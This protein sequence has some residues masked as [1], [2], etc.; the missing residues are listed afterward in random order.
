MISLI[1]Q[2]F[3]EAPSQML[4]N[5]CWKKNVLDFVSRHY[6]TGEPL[7]ADLI[8][9]MQKAKDV[10]QGLFN[11]RQL[12]FGLFDMKL[13]TDY[14]STTESD[15]TQLW[16]SMRQEI[17]LLDSSPDNPAGQASFAHIMGGYEAGYYGYMWSKVY[18]SDMFTTKFEGHELD[19]QVGAMYRDTVLKPGGSRDAIDSLRL[20]LGREPNNKAFLRELSLDS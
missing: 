14:N 1:C 2:D 4:E 13:H 12:H 10:G 3:V 9:K 11:L 5:W 8:E 17:A 18:S 15:L 19:P 16:N 20:F 6:E 7:P